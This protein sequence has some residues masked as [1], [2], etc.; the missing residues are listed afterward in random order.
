[1]SDDL[2]HQ[3]DAWEVAVGHQQIAGA[4]QTD[5][6]GGTA[7]FGVFERD[8]AKGPA[9]AGPQ[10]DQADQAGLRFLAGP[11]LIGRGRIDGVQCSVQVSLGAVQAQQAEAAP[12]KAARELV[13][14]GVNQPLEQAAEESEGQLFAGGAEGFLGYRLGPQAWANGPQRGPEVDD[15]SG[16][17]PVAQ[18]GYGH[19]PEHDAGNQDHVFGS[20]SLGAIFEQRVENSIK[21]FQS[22]TAEQFDGG[23]RRSSDRH[24]QS[25]L[26]AR[27]G[28]DYP[29]HRHR[30][31]CV[32]RGLS[33]SAI[34]LTPP[35]KYCRPSG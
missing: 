27:F 28:C 14:E 33:F 10:V 29:I 11:M 3:A 9:Q 24:K 30:E 31:D 23:G 13:V 25:S 18:G 21:W 19:Q 16:H 17:G 1:M 6:A 35:A 22:A 20:P 5:Q 4:E 12:E 32:Y 34:G 7:L 2:K 26:T 15:R 8:E